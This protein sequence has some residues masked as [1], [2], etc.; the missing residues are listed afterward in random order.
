MSDRKKKM[1]EV[2]RRVN[3]IKQEMD[4]A[5]QA[6]DV[7]RLEREQQG[8]QFLSWGVSGEVPAGCV[9]GRVHV[10]VGSEGATWTLCLNVEERWA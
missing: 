6:L 9:F 1:S 5:R 10:R 7:Q 2:T 8:K 3:H 4:T